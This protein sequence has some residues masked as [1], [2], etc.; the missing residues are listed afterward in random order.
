M[1]FTGALKMP[2][3]NF[4][5]AAA[6]P[7]AHRGRADP[8]RREES[9][10]AGLAGGRGV[11]GKKVEGEPAIVDAAALGARG[12]EDDAPPDDAG[13][14]KGFGEGNAGKYRVN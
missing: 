3:V 13:A 12:V 11:A 5:H 9:D 10:V 4:A 14:G 1:R 7:V 2:P 6:E 8:L